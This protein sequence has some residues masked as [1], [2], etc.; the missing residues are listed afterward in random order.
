MAFSRNRAPAAAATGYREHATR[1]SGV[2]SQLSPVEGGGSRDPV[3]GLAGSG[4]GCSLAG[5]RCFHGIDPPSSQATTWSCLDAQGQSQECSSA[6][7]PGTSGRRDSDP[8]QGNQAQEQDCH[9]SRNNGGACRLS[10]LG[11]HQVMGSP[12]ELLMDHPSTDLGPQMESVPSADAHE[13][14]HGKD[15]HELEAPTG[16]VGSSVRHRTGGDLGALRVLREKPAAAQGSRDV[17]LAQIR[18]LQRGQTQMLKKGLQHAQQGQQ[19]LREAALAP[20]ERKFFLLEILGTSVSLFAS[21]TD[22]WTALEPVDLLCGSDINSKHEQDRVLQQLDAMSPDLVLICP[23]CGPWSSLQ[24]INDQDVVVWKRLMSYHLWEFTRKVWDLQTSKG[25][26]CLTEQPWLSKALELQIM[27][28]RPHLHRAIIDQCA[29]K[30]RDPENKK[31]MRK[32]TVLDCNSVRFAAL[33]EEGAQCTHDRADHQ[34]IEGA[35]LV[36]GH[37]VNRSLIAGMW[38]KE[39]C[40]HIMNAAERTLASVEPL[41]CD[42]AVTL[43]TADDP[44]IPIGDHRCDT[45]HAHADICCVHCVAMMCESCSD[46]H[47]CCMHWDG[48]EPFDC[49]CDSHL[50]CVAE[51]QTPTDQIVGD[52]ED[53]AEHAIR[54]EFKRLQEEED[55]RKG[56]FSGIGS[57]YGYV[58][59]VGPSIRLPREVRNQ[60]A[61]LHGLFGHP[62]NERLARML[63]ING[64]RKAVI[65]GAKSLRCSICERISGPRSAPQAS[66]KAPSRLNEQCVL[67]SFFI[68]DCNGQRWNVTHILDGFCS[69]QYGICSKKCSK[70]RTAF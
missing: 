11:P 65:E 10:S 37:W 70:C 53:L 30:L 61:K 67:D 56:D 26:L 19:L 5:G 54:K 27:T 2:G 22:N 69:L 14:S 38:T 9:E 13:A 44:D 29:F 6:I 50:A 42:R 36:N 16:L 55:Q 48:H 15:P 23:P 58:R 49:P 24:A 46:H 28:S 33:L 34:V 35:T 3:T 4:G 59:F 20:P 64:A 39:L 63:Q 8:C 52:P 31:P 62:S 17:P 7:D 25:N 32:R 12:D 18:S 21:S 1:V 41:P 60:L 51:T 40:I 45:C 68:L 43:T 47:V 66:A 57:R